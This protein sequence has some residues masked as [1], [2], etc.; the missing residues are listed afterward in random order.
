MGEHLKTVKK[1]LKNI[2]LFLYPTNEIEGTINEGIKNSCE[3][4]KRV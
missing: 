3:K 4:L 1:K 2:F